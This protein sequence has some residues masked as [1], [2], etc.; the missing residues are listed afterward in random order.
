M[1]RPAPGRALRSLVPS[2][3]DQRMFLLAA[4]VNTYGTG[5]VVTAVTLFGLKVVHLTAARLGLAMTIGG[6][7]SLVAVM[8]MGR[9]ADRLGPRDVYRAALLLWG[10]AAAGLVFLAHG[11]V[12]FLVITTVQGLAISAS[13]PASVALLRRVG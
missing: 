9:L 1:A 10:A 6:L 12:S 2:S 13:L 5:L 8:P 7:V 4:L 11:F 3:R